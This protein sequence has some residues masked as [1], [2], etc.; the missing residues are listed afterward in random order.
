MIIDAIRLTFQ[1]MSP[2]HTR[3]NVLVWQMH[4]TYKNLISTFGI[5]LNKYGTKKNSKEIQ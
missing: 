4:S 3:I 2:Y 1:Q 5:W